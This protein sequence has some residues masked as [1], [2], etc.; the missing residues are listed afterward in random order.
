MSN[1]F[2]QIQYPSGRKSTFHV[3]QNKVKFEAGYVQSSRKFTKGRWKW[4]LTWENARISD[5]EKVRQHFNE[6]A[7][8]SFI[9]GWAMLGSDKDMTV[10]YSEDSISK[11]NTIKGWCSFEVALEEA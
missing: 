11:T 4:T 8:D 5:F 3:G 9:C 7:G 2:P 1:Q 6:N 10:R